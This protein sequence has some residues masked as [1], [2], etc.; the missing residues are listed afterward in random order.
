[1]LG[2]RK[3]APQSNVRATANCGSTPR[4]PGCERQYT[5]QNDGGN[6]VFRRP[7][8]PALAW[9]QRGSRFADAVG[10]QRL[11]VDSLAADEETRDG[12][13]LASQDPF[14]KKVA[15]YVNKAESS[16]AP[17]ICAIADQPHERK[18]EP[19]A[20]HFGDR[21]RPKQPNIFA[22]LPAELGGLVV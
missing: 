14:L 9:V 2:W 4:H 12:V 16:E 18:L 17:L 7:V 19:H 3:C 1:M 22:F 15:E 21:P 11:R 5:Y 20:E 10:E 8:N 13:D 6:E